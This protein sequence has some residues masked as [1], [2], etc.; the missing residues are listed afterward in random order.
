MLK[1]SVISKIWLFHLVCRFWCKWA[2][3][4][5]LASQHPLWWDM[6]PVD[7]SSQWKDDGCW[8][9]VDKQCTWDKPYCLAA[10]NWLPLHSCSDCSPFMVRLNRFWTDQGG[11]LNNLHNW[12]LAMLSLCLFVWPAIDCECHSRP[13]FLIRWMV[14]RCSGWKLSYWL[15]HSQ[16]EIKLSGL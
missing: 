13:V 8:S 1:D 6:T 16:N 11:C 9:H 4:L 5:Q 14:M 15:Q 10:R 7:V 3:P 12:G 2:S